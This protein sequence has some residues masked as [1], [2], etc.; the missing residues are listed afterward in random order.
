MLYA[1][2]L[3]EE[4]GIDL[5]IEAARDVPEVDL[6]IAGEGP[7]GPD[8]RRRT[9]GIDHV[10]WLGRLDA[11]P[12]RAAMAAQAEQLGEQIAANALATAAYTYQAFSDEELEA[13]AEALEH[14]TMQ[15]VY[16]LMNAV[17]YEIM[18]N[19]FEAV[20]NRLAAMQP[21]QDL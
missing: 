17:Q 10:H 18:A 20:A 16:T 14:P 19:R 11:D 3:S 4:K 12:L 8:L 21:S 1:G 15:E 5:L 13:Y 9:E 2:R 6:H 7:E